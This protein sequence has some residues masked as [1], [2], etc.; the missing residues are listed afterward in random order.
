M[1]P[2]MPILIRDAGHQGRDVRGGR[3]HGPAA[4]RQWRGSAPALNPNP[5]R[6]ST[7]MA[8]P[9]PL[10]ANPGGSRW[11]SKP[12][13]A[14]AM[15]AKAPIGAASRCACRSGRS[16][17]P[18]GF[19]VPGLPSSPE[20]KLGAPCLPRPAETPRC[21][22]H[23]PAAP[24][25]PPEGPGTASPCWFPPGGP[26]IADSVDRGAPGDQEHRHQEEGRDGVEGQ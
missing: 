3:R 20:G 17:R 11:S 7:N 22:P 23:P 13:M 25:M 8:V 18:V 5:S 15:T 16:R 12:P 4:A 6:N 2:R 19:R 1:K 10:E 26:P 24:G 9:L 14:P 21:G